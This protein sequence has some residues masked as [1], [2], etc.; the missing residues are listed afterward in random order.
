MSVV[1]FSVSELGALSQMTSISVASAS[2][3]AKVL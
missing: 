2:H 3:V 1:V